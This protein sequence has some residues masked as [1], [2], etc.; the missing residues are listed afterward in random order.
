MIRKSYVTV[1]GIKY[2]EMGKNIS[3]GDTVIFLKDVKNNYDDEA[4]AVFSHDKEKIGYVA[5]S[6]RTVARGTFSAGRLYDKFDYYTVGAI[7][8]IL[9]DEAIVEVFYKEN[10]FTMPYDLQIKSTDF[11]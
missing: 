7:R 11:K 6:T 9:K 3:V 1:T 2:Y 4:I 8:F 10:P 5:N